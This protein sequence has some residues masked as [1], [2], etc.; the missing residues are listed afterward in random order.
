M[1]RYSVEGTWSDTSVL[2]DHKAFLFDRSRDLL[3]IPVSICNERWI[4]ETLFGSQWQGA[5]VFNVTLTNG[6]ALTGNVTHQVAGVNEW[7]SSLWIKRE[8]YI[9]QV[10]YTM[11]DKKLKLNNLQD[12]AFIKEIELG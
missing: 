8:F 7:D 12:L 9:E 4:N 3:S 2:T 10:L 1:S 11:S 6:L 5:L